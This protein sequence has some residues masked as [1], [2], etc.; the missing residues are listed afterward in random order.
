MYIDGVETTMQF[1][2]DTAGA[3][4]WADNMVLNVSGVGCLYRQSISNY[5]NGDIQFVKIYDRILS[6]SE[7]KQ[8]YD[9]QKSRY[10]S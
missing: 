6:L 4:D 9:S 2:T 8:N 7:V 1:A 5:F 3:D 10:G